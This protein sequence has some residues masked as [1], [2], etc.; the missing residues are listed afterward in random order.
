MPKLT[1]SEER[2][3]RLFT[4]KFNLPEK[5]YQEFSKT[6]AA[7]LDHF[8]SSNGRL[9]SICDMFVDMGPTYRDYSI[10]FIMGYFMAIFGQER[11]NKF[12]EA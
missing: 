6:L 10:L 3:F 7:L 2:R 11:I 8:E 4:K 1:E 9:Y 5:E 12:N